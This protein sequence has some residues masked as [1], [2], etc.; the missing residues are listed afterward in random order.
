MKIN[1]NKY[2]DLELALMVML[3]YFGYGSSRKELLGNRYKQVQALVN[4]ICS[5]TMPEGNNY[6][7]RLVKALH[8]LRPTEQDY[9]DYIDSIISYI[10]EDAQ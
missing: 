4:Q 10:K 9:N 6:E 2:N 7:E 3:N 8:K 5:G 1:I